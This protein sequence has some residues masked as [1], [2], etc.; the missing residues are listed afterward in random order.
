MFDDKPIW[1]SKTFWL[2]LLGGAVML[3]PHFAELLPPQYAAIALAAA[4]I[5]NRFFTKKEV[6]LF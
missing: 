4:N 3:L 1:Q 5:L 2:N 6:T